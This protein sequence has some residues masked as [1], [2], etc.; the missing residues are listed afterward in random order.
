MIE[1]GYV[2]LSQSKIQSKS[3]SQHRLSADRFNIMLEF[4]SSCYKLSK[5]LAYCP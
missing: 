3:N 4:S 5:I 1:R 2:V